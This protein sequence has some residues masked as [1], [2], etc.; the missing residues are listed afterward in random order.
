[1]NCTT[2][3]ATL[4]LPEPPG[5][6]PEQ[7]GERPQEGVGDHRNDDEIEASPQV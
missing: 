1:M 3:E 6:H 5:I 7:A 2:E 4:G